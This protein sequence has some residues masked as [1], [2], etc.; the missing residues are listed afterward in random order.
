MFV[1]TIIGCRLVVSIYDNC[2]LKRWSESKFTKV[3]S[4]Q[5]I[6][7]YLWNITVR[8]TYVYIFLLFDL[9]RVRTN[10]II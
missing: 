2:I 1:C 10:E 4:V 9:V 6:L 8:E 3:R 7:L 5:L